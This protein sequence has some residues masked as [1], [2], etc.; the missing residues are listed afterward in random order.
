MNDV[1][2]KNLCELIREQGLNVIQN[3]NKF[4]NFLNDYT[5][6]TK[7]DFKK[8]RKCL[9]DALTEG[10]PDTLLA[11]KNHLS[12]PQLS[13]QL[14]QKLVNNL[15]IIPE[16][17]QW[18]VDSWALALGIISESDLL[19]T[20]S[21]L[22]IAS[23]PPGANVYINN[24]LVGFSPYQVHDLL[25]GLYH[26]RVELSGYDIWKED[27]VFPEGQKI[28]IHANLIKEVPHGEVF[29]NTYPSGASINI[30]PQ[31]YGTTPQK[32]SQILIGNHELSLSLAGYEKIHKYIQI[33]PGKNH[34]IYENLIP[35][36]YAPQKPEQ[37]RVAIF[38]SPPHAMVY[39]NTQY[40]GQTPI[41]LTGITP[42]TYTLMLSQSGYE[43]HSQEI[44]LRPGKNADISWNLQPK[45]VR[46]E[47]IPWKTYGVAAF[48]AI[49]FV[50]FF[51][52]FIP[53]PDI[54]TETGESSYTQSPTATPIATDPRAGCTFLPENQLLSEKLPSGYVKNYY[55]EVTNP[56]LIRH[57]RIRVEGTSDFDFIVAKEYIPSF[58]PK[59]YD[60]IADM[61]L[62]NEEL[63]ITDLKPGT[64]FVQ[65]RNKGY[66]SSFTIQKTIFYK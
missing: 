6:Y 54:N 32:I 49:A 57:I 37:S 63:D 17:A 43:T 42:G 45:Y 39:L 60:Q 35:E 50:F 28:T 21:T 23:N 8:E 47:S 48:C 16:L 11:K 27:V 29:I 64:Y 61:D 40:L 19:K 58:N 2:R 46:R 51:L 7:G 38:S 66:A 5:D 15:G 26:L 41:N 36:K 10:I 1:P 59:H 33:H 30:G 14:S 22:H 24:A 56:D 55:F 4:Q 13:Q 9:N 52:G 12:Y 31:F 18:T 3:A 53:L 62:Y 25:P 44:A 20:T 65:V 34:D